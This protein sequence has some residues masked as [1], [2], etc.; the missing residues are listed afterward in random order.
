[1]L[2]IAEHAWPVEPQAN[3][4]EGVIIINMAADRV[5]MEGNK[6]GG[7]Q[8]RGHHMEFAV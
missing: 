7:A 1:M 2:D 3:V 4:F 8:R 5:G 6:N